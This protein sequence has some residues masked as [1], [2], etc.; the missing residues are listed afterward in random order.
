MN[1]TEK[2]LLAIHQ[3]VS[4]FGWT[5]LRQESRPGAVGVYERLH[6]G[7]RAA[8]V[9]ENNVFSLKLLTVECR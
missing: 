8:L 3:A 7:K 2:T 4:E 5:L 6:D 1:D 9:L